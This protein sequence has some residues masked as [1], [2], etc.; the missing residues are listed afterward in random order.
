MAEK[1]VPADERPRTTEAWE[2]RSPLRYNSGRFITCQ[3]VAVGS[4]KVKW[5]RVLNLSVKGI[6][7]R[8]PTYFAPGTLLK[9]ALA[10]VTS[11]SV[12]V[13]EGRVIHAREEDAGHYF[14]GA[15]L[16]SELNRTELRTL[17]EESL[18]G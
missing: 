14:T 11:S 4:D 6:G 2:R 8:T 12:H 3:V 1:P 13:L 7:L 10:K 5:A 16:A 18:L 9:I 17:I 15:L